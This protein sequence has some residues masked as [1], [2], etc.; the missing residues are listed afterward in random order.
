MNGFG[1]AA[2]V[3]PLSGREVEILALLAEGLSNREIADRLYISTETVKWYNKQL[4]GKLG[5]HSRSQAVAM[6]REHGLLEGSGEKTAGEPLSPKHNLPAQLTSFVGREREIAELKELLG[7][8]RLITLTGPGGTGKTRLCLQVAEGLAGQYRDGVTFVGL[9]S[10]DDPELVPNTVARELGVIEQANQPL[11]GLLQRYLKEKQLLLVIDNFEHVLDA[12]PMVTDL[13]AA[14]PH[15]DVLAT[16]REALRLSGEFDYPVSPLSVPDKSRLGPAS[17][18]LTYESVALFSQRAQAAA[19]SF[20][21]TEKNTPAVAAIC[22]RLDGLP[23]AIELAAVRIKLFKPKQLLERLE[24]SLGLLTRGPRDLPARQR[25]LR[26]AIDWSHNL[27]DRGEQI[28]FAR[29]GVFQGGRSIDA[30]EAICGPGLPIDPLD[31]LETL[32]DKCLLTQEEGLGGEPRFVMLETIH[33]YARE[34][35]AES[36]EELLIRDRHLEYF[37]ALAEEMEPGYRRHNQLHLLKRTEAEM[38]NLRVALNWTLER[39]DVETGAQL[40]S[41]IDYFLFYTDRFVEG[42]RWINRL[43]KNIN[44]M[45]PEYQIRLLITAGH[46]A[47]NT[48]DI[49]QSKVFC[50]KALVLAQEL[51]DKANTAWALIYLGGA[52]IGRP[53]ECKEAVIFC[54][55]GLAIFQELGDKPGMA[56]AL[57][58]L[59]ELARTV[60]DYQRAHDVYDVSLAISRQTGEIIRQIMLQGNLSFVAYQEA[61]YESARDLCVLFLSQMVEIGTKLGTLNGLAQLAGPLGKLGEPEKAARLLG[62]TAALMSAMG[63][64][65]QAGDQLEIDKYEADIRAQLDE[66]VFEAAWVEGQAMT[67]E[68]AYAYA[69]EGV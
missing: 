14:A 63:F 22:T 8:A 54:E 62:A 25:T 49:E 16:S 17:D 31:G 36:G 24:D 30:V 23:L 18:L 69:L 38:D 39:G 28:L 64:D 37:L 66:G 26:S 51:G 11:I 42:Y 10:I 65:H 20:R 57:N 44:E 7:K 5:V 35:L 47:Y 56:H 9:A 21:L 34:R 43:L 6:A 27:L 59:G 61:N 48:G 19:P 32:L 55:E 13:L 12:A 4:Y 3:D 52:S 33:E 67:L 41:A 60:G 46:L 58:I 53:E 1:K 68:E 15:L 50:R 29:L 40:V 2:V 45:A